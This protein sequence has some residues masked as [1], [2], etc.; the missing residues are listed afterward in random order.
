MKKFL[1]RRSVTA[2]IWL[3]VLFALNPVFAKAAA[4][5][6]GNEDMETKQDP[7][8]LSGY[9]YIN[10]DLTAFLSG[11]YTKLLDREFDVD[12]LEYWCRIYFTNEMT[13]EEIIENGFLHSEEFESKDLDNKT[14]IVK[15]YEA[16]FNREPDEAGLCDWVQRLES[17]KE[18]RDSVIRGFVYS[19]EFSKRIFYIEKPAVDLMI[20]MGQSNMSGGGGNA[21][22]APV[23]TRGAGYEFRAVTNTGDLFV[24]KEPFGEN[25][26]KEGG[27][28]DRFILKRSGT[29]VTAFVNA[30]YENTKTP[31]IAVSASRGSTHM[32]EWT[33]GGISLKEDAAE[34]LMCAKNY[35]EQNGFGIRHIYMVWFQGE[36]DGADRTSADVYKRDFE[37]LFSYMQGYGV[38]KCFLIET[39]YD[40]HDLEQED[41]EKIEGYRAI[42]QAQEEICRESED[43]ILASTTAPGLQSR[44]DKWCDGV[45]FNQESLNKIGR[46]AGQRA[47][48]YTVY[49][50]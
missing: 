38:E 47:G 22:E 27:C 2:M 10:P 43:V 9:R 30:Y 14:F 29:L 21:A 37:Y 31:V 1:Y 28:D 39:G 5:R 7:D 45:H 17:G 25:E 18:T 50:Q 34:R 49:G 46:E 40:L 48:E 11:I 4:C 12:G 19:E 35:L 15:M 33:G 36:S 6:D 26:N 24:L 42:M 8:A 41:Q 16:F 23:L 3:A 20:F 32:K 44:D 13:L